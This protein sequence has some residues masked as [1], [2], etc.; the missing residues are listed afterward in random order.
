M[1]SVAMMK[2]SRLRPMSAWY[3]TQ[4]SG[5]GVSGGG[6]V[7]VGVGVGA[8]VGV[9]VAVGLGVGVGA[10]V[11][12]GAGLGVAVGAGVGLGAG[13]TVAV[14]VGRLTGAVGV[15]RGRPTGNSAGSG[16]GV[17]ATTVTRSIG[18]RITP[19]EP[20]L[21]AIAIVSAH[22]ARAAAR[23]QNGTLAGKRRAAQ[24]IQ[25]VMRR[26]RATS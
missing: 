22:P 7:G 19:D 10:G 14:G 16:A 2:I 20:P 11:A 24:R 25:R 23:F 4:K 15:W 26:A 3:A 13:V 8:G 21:Q 17:V 18:T 5:N 1:P 6:G 9:G 12:V